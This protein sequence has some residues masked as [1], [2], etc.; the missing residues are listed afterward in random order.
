MNQ[1]EMA[2]RKIADANRG[3]DLET[4]VLVWDEIKASSRVVERG[5][6]EFRD[7]SL[8][9][10][11]HNLAFA[12]RQAFDAWFKEYVTVLPEKRGNAT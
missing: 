4:Q 3:R 9:F 5:L 2:A 6:D 11:R 12:D 8:L 10:E 7:G 1:A